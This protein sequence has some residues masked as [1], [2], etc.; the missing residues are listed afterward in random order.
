MRVHHVI[1]F[2]VLAIVVCVVDEALAVPSNAVE[3]AIKSL[4]ATMG[5]KFDKLIAAVNAI[6]KGKPTVN[7]AGKFCVGHEK[8]FVRASF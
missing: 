1:W 7:P 2:F 5:K 4:E 6:A 3:T 8:D